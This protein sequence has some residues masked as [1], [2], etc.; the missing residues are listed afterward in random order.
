MRISGLREHI[1]KAESGRPWTGFCVVKS[2]QEAPV[3]SKR[4]PQSRASPRIAHDLF[5]PEGRVPRTEGNQSANMSVTPTA[6]NF[7]ILQLKQTVA[8]L[9]ERIRE[10]ERDLLAPEGLSTPSRSPGL[11]RSMR[12][13]FASD[14]VSTKRQRCK[15]SPW[16]ETLVLAGDQ[17]AEAAGIDWARSRGAAEQCCSPY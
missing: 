11:P 15:A 13:L 10:Q 4:L 2:T 5:A 3:I 12:R 9:H 8:T 17:P 14:A 1:Q 6:A 16:W 7:Q